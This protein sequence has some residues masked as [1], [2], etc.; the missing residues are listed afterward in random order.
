M[1]NVRI[2]DGD[3]PAGSGVEG[4]RKKR[5]DETPA[6]AREKPEPA[7]ERE[8]QSS[9]RSRHV[10]PRIGGDDGGADIFYTGTK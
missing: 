2:N 4:A 1:P 8:E 7:T 10:R 5:P 3:L 9:G 6:P